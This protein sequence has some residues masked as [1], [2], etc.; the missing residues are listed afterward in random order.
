M[1]LYGT[2]S[3][4]VQES[5]YPDP[6]E[7]IVPQDSVPVPPHV[8]SFIRHVFWRQ[9]SFTHHIQHSITMAATATRR[10]TLFRLGNVHYLLS[11]LLTLYCIMILFY[12]SQ[13]SPIFSPKDVCRLSLVAHKFTNTKCLSGAHSPH[14]SC[15]ILQ[16]VVVLWYPSSLRLQL[17]NPVRE[18]ARTHSLSNGSTVYRLSLIS[19][20]IAPLDGHL[21]L[22]PQPTLHHYLLIN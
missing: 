5:S 9:A 6:L 10:A 11:I 15:L 2:S 19:L 14:L 20:I 21:S 16:L 7:E 18:N 4:G 3:E 13:S 17:S 1:Y 22:S 12:Y 8:K